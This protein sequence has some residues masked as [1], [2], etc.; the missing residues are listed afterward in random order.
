MAKP[1][2][3]NEGVN[4]QLRGDRVEVGMAGNEPLDWS[5]ELGIPC[6]LFRLGTNHG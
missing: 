6:C 5:S 1:G 4:V 2:T 3:I